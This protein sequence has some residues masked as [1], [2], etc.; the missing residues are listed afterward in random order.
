MKKA[1]T[2]LFMLLLMFFISCDFFVDIL[3]MRL[4]EKYE[5]ITY[6][7]IKNAKDRGEICLSEVLIP[8]NL[9]SNGE[10]I[11]LYELCSYADCYL[12]KMRASEAAG[13][14]SFDYE[15]FYGD[16]SILANGSTS[17]TSGS[18]DLNFLPNN[19]EF[20]TVMDFFWGCDEQLGRNALKPAEVSFFGFSPNSNVYTHNLNITYEGGGT[21]TTYPPMPENHRFYQTT[22]VNLYPQP[23][24]TNGW[25]FL[26]W[27]GTNGAE[28]GPNTIEMNGDKCI[29]AAFTQK[30][31]SIYA[32]SGTVIPGGSAGFTFSLNPAPETGTQVTVSFLIE[33]VVENS[34]YIPPSQNNIKIIGPNSTGSVGITIL[35]GAVIGKQ[36]KLTITGADNDYYAIDDATSVA[37]ITIV[38]P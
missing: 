1:A 32:D 24:I 10:K 21:V 15:T 34:D 16:G 35:T 3:L 12:G 30:L 26:N 7:D 14:L 25:S 27:T 17:I 23:D 28:V 20:A 19:Q 11:L 31:V 6:K 29:T 22:L 37:I 4:P 2:L 13:V 5:D 33:G 9:F 8:D 18:Y 38:S 36:I